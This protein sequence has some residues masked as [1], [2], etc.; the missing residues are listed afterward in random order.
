MTHKSYDQCSCSLHI[1]HRSGSHFYVTLMSTD[2][3]F[4]G[5]LCF[6]RQLAALQPGFQFVLAAGKR[7]STPETSRD[8]YA[9]HSVQKGQPA[10]HQSW[11]SGP[12]SATNLIWHMYTWREVCP[13]NSTE[14]R[15]YLCESLSVEEYKTLSVCASIDPR[16]SQKLNIAIKKVMMERMAKMF[17]CS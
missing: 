1:F 8:R 10:A 17:L 12:R 16:I 4:P 7:S 5:H 15:K 14:L 13:L 2:I 3:I 11:P 9:H 6:D